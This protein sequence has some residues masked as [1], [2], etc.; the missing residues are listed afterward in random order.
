MKTDRAMGA[1][2]TALAAIIWGAW[3]LVLRPSGLPAVQQAFLALLVMASPLPFV[4][5][6]EPFAD[7]GAVVALLLLG[8]ADAG[9]IGFYFAAIDR[10]PVAVAVLSHYLAPILVTLAAPLVLGERR[11]RRALPAALLSLLG[12]GLLVWRPGEQVSLVTAGLGAASAVF[13][14]GFVFASHRAGQA[15]PAFAVVALH[16]LVSA[17]VLLLVFG[18]DAVPAPGPGALRVALGSLV[19]GL[20]ATG[21][22]FRGVTMIPAAVTGALTYLEPLTAALVGYLAFGEAIG[23]GGAVGVGLVLVSGVAVATEP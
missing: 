7:R 22:F 14:A 18:G 23:L 6:R 16:A 19:C 15:F 8:V 1:G 2:L 21:L 9:S 11:S 13:Y 10:G 3:S 5:R 4:L 20:L 17:G 12:I